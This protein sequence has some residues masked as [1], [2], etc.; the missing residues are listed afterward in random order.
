[1]KKNIAQDVVF[2]TSEKT[3]K[4]VIAAKISEFHAGIIECRL[5]DSGVTDEGKR[6]AI[7]RIAELLKSGNTLE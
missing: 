2:H 6:E 3:D 7:D 1:M 5:N 4:A